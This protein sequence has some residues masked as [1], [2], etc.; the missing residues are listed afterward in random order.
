VREACART[1]PGWDDDARRG[2]SHMT[3]W[4]QMACWLAMDDRADIGAP[5][6]GPAARK[7]LVEHLYGMANLQET[8]WLEWK[9]GYDL[10]TPAGRARTAKHILG[11]ANRMPDLAERHAGGYAYLLLGVEP[12]THH[13]VDVHDS[14]D[15]ENW[16]CPYVADD[17]V[18]GRRLHDFKTA[19]LG[20]RSL[21]PKAKMALVVDEVVPAIA[22]ALATVQP[23][24]VV[25]AVC[26]PGVRAV[27][28]GC[29]ALPLAKDAMVRASG[30]CGRRARDGRAHGGHGSDH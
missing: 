2:N 18:F 19:L 30:V 5:A 23:I 26:P 13:G 7:A 6:R 25:V 3:R 17:V 11:F 14:A 4:L 20:S 1:V 29:D 8:D 24:L 10:T 28:P 16:L 15:L 21:G 27:L 22:I 9:R 12:G